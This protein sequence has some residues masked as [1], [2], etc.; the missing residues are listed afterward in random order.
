MEE[1]RDFGGLG[2]SSSIRTG[3]TDNPGT[4]TAAAPANDMLQNL[5]QQCLAY[6]EQQQ[7]HQPQQYQ[8][9]QQNA[10]IYHG[11]HQGDQYNSIQPDQKD[12]PPR[13]DGPY[14]FKAGGEERI[15][16]LIGG[17]S[18][19][20]TIIVQGS[21]SEASAG[22]EGCTSDIQKVA[23][24][25]RSRANAI[26]EKFQQLT[27]E[28]GN[29]EGAENDEPFAPPSKFR[30]KRERFF[31]KENQRKHK[32]LLKNL[33]YVGKRQNQRL[34]Q[35]LSQLGEAQK[36]ESQLHDHYNSILEQRKQKLSTNQSL[37]SEAGIGTGKRQ[38]VEREK[39]RKGHVPL[40]NNTSQDISLAVYL[41]GLT[42]DDSFRE[43]TLN[44]LFGS[45]GIIRKIHPYRNKQTGKLK[46]DALVIYQVKPEEKDDLLETVCSQVRFLQLCTW[47]ASSFL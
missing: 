3:D 17:N 42:T 16:E 8:P 20:R 31:E 19:P 43:D 7:Q 40:S 36:Y 41:S 15:N 12:S 25:G 27:R 35:T 1:G 45:Y 14:G 30:E 21:S 34:Q 10:Q 38:R 2:F 26:L 18:V 46:G 24:A 33:D 28:H 11:Q 39:S 5:M 44:Q 22:T 32:F 23:E 9:L 4:G 47:L 29:M 13:E 6:H 37:H